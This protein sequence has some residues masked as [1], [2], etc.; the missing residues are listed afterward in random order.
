MGTE[1]SYGKIEWRATTFKYTNVLIKCGYVLHSSEARVIKYKITELGKKYI[2]DNNVYFNDRDK[3]DKEEKNK[4]P[5]Y[6][7]KEIYFDIETIK[8][9]IDIQKRE[10]EEQK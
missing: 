10:F 1:D 7:V 9:S 3:L 4:E 8:N 2:N 5:I 6:Q